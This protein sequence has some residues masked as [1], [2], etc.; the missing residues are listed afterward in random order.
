MTADLLTETWTELPLI[1]GMVACVVVF[2]WR[3]VR[4][5]DKDRHFV[6]A[7]LM[8]ALAILIPAAAFALYRFGHIPS[9]PGY[10]DWEYAR[11][12]IEEARA[13]LRAGLCVC[14]V[15]L[16]IHTTL[17]LLSRSKSYSSSAIEVS[18]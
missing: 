7:R 18:S 16:V 6:N 11:H 8:L 2:G 17:W 1:Y 14:A 9:A 5:R 13:P 10:V 3:C 12:K 4:R 15:M